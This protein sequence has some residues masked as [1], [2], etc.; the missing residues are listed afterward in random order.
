MPFSFHF[1]PGSFQ[2]F[3]GFQGY[4]SNGGADDAPPPKRTRKPRKPIGNAFTRTLINLGVTLVFALVYFYAE[5]PAINLHAE[6]FYVFAFLV[7][8]VY[9]VCAVL[10]SGFQ[11]DGVKGYVGFVKKQ[12]TVPF[13][14]FIALIAVIAVGS[15]TSWVVLRAGAYS[16][17]LTIESGD[18]TAEIEEISYDQIPMLDASSASRLGSRKLGEL[19]DMVSQF[20]ILPTYNQINYQGRPVRVTSLAYGDLIKWFTNRS[21]GLPAYI[22]IDMVTQ[23]ANVIRLEEGMKYTTAEHFGRNLYRHLRFHYPTMMFDEPVF[24][25]DESGTPYWVCSRIVKTIGLFGGTDIQGAVL[26]NAITGESTYYEEV[27]SWVDRVYSSDIIMEQYDYYGMYHNGFL[28][29]IFGQR[30]VTLTTDGW[31]Y[32]A[33]NDDVYMYTGVTSVTS[34]QSN[35]GFILSNQRTKETHF[36]S[37]AGATE[38]SAMESAQSQVQQMRYN[39]TFPLLL[40][41]ADQP[42]YFMALKG[43]DGLVKMYAMVNVEQYQIV[44]TGQTV[45]ACES[46]YRQ[47]LANAGLIGAG[48]TGVSGGDVRTQDGIIAEIRTS[49]IDG[50]TH[51]YV[52]LENGI[53]FLD[54]NAAQV[55]RAVLLDVGD[56]IWYDYAL[57]GADFPENGIVAASGFRFAGEEASPAA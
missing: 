50:N 7:C 48:Q 56:H 11:G 2:G 57:E 42:T 8:A 38:T 10:T 51:F 29:S 26:V 32:I 46:N 12:C 17:L 9:C 15:I 33:I 16:Q 19:S 5:L 25:I 31:N 14:A 3:Q 6:E 20:E 49:V 34:D 35:I 13:L 18:F 40:N 53:G 39:A 21:Q 30:D 23:E 54:F 52:R 36:Y 55:P 27:P 44:E 41:I 37:I 1:D 24:E 22:V 43:D 4:A 45:A 28:N 47:A